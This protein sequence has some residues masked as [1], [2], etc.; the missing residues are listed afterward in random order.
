MSEALAN[1]REKIVEWAVMAALVGV[2]GYLIGNSDATMMRVE[3]DRLTADNARQEAEIAAQSN[4]YDDLAPRVLTLE[5]Q[6]KAEREER[7]KGDAK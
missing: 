5:V 2:I 1:L 3:I 4:R 7:L 6:A